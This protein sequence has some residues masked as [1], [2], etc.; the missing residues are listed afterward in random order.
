MSQY[1]RSMHRK[2]TPAVICTTL[3]VRADSDSNRNTEAT[4]QLQQLLLDLECRDNAT[5]NN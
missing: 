4:I 3:R 2:W 5:E 1:I